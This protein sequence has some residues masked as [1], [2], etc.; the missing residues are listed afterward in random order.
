[1]TDQNRTNALLNAYFKSSTSFTVT[2]GTGGG[3]AFTITP[4]YNLRLMS[5]QGSN[6]ANGTEQASGNGYTTGGSSLGAT[7]AGT[8]ASGQFSNANAVSWTATGTWSPATQTSIEIWDTA[9]TPLRY[10]QGALTS[11][12][13]GVANGDTVT[14]AAASITVNA[15]AW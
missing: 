12:I 13:T 9:G 2:P 4:P 5:T 15:S 10:L 3:S 7:F 11:S 8:V 1:M 6:T 14:F